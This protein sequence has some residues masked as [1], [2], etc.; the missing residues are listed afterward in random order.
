MSLRVSGDGQYLSRSANLPSIT[1][2]TILGKSY[3]VSDRGTG[4]S[5]QLVDV[6]G[7]GVDYAARLAYG[8]FSNTMTVIANGSSGNLASR[9]ATS[10]WFLWY[11]QCS[12]SWSNQIEGGWGYCDDSSSVVKANCTLNAGDTSTVAIY[13]G[14]ISVLNSWWADARYQDIIV[15]NDVWTAAEINAQRYRRRLVHGANTNVWAHGRSAATASA[16]ATDYSGNGRNFTVNGSPTIEADIP[17]YVQEFSLAGM[18][19]G[20]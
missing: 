6:A 20:A 15:S 10:R 18:G 9:P 4:Q 13:I 14:T 2:F 1:S 19:A 7:N 12:G 3:I 5:Q 11:L 16:A 17:N 8:D